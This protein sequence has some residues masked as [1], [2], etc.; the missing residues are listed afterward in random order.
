MTHTRPS[1]DGDADHKIAAR[2]QLAGIFERRGMFEEAAD[3]LV[4]NVRDGVRNADIFR[5][6]A[7]LFRAQGDEVTASDD[8]RVATAE[9]ATCLRHQETGRQT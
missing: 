4:S 7:R 5:W 2:E 9:V 6:L 3:L 1:T 8:A